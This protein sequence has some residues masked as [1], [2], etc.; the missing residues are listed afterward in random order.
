MIV[1]IHYQLTADQT[2]LHE[3][4]LI[5][6]TSLDKLKTKKSQ[7]VSVNAQNDYF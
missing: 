3:A 1:C 4:N 7:I 5:L 2:H 6:D